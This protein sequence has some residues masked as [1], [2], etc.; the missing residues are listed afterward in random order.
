MGCFVGNK[1]EAFASTKFLIFKCQE[2]TSPV[3]DYI[4]K[5]HTAAGTPL[6]SVGTKK[7]TTEMTND[8]PLSYGRQHIDEDDI[9]HVVRACRGELITRGS[10]VAEFEARVAAYCGAKWAV[11]VANAT[12]GLYIAFQAARASAAD[13]VITTPNS[14]IATVAAGIR[15]G[16][17][18]HFVDIDRDSGNMDLGKLEAA[19]TPRSSGRYI[20]APVHF[21]GIAQD[22]RRLS[23]RLKIPD[24]V[25]IEDAAQALGSEYPGGGLVGSCAYSDM[26]VFSFHAIKN[27]TTAEGGIVTTNSDE[28]YQ[29]LLM[30]RNS[31]IVKEKPLLEEEPAPGYYEVHEISGNYHMSELHAALGVSQLA[32]LAQ[33]VEKRRTIVSWY[34]HHLGKELPELRLFGAAHDPIT[35]YHLFVVQCDFAAR[36]LNRAVV[37]QRLADKGIGTQYHYV[38]LYRH[39]AIR[40]LGGQRIED[41]PEMEAYFHQ[42]LT[43]PLF[44]DLEERDVVRVV[45]ALKEAL[46]E[47][48]P[49]V[50]R[51]PAAAPKRSRR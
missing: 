28:L 22:M 8:R 45:Q 21:A 51:T 44:Y 34:R 46:K 50:G 31:G 12:C 47:A 32:K 16:A 39:P 24:V 3:E 18:P 27:I 4:S 6:Y 10:W 11:A 1:S 26:T 9:A 36:N 7:M 19:L 14:F 33:F 41:Y 25:I 13:R 29:R 38:P 17:R 5:P 48:R 43:L 30:L 23:Q 15:C 49:S 37:M 35:A 42:A 20:I 40:R 2:Y